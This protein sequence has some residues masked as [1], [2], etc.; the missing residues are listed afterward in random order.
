MSSLLTVDEFCDEFKVG[1]T[2]AYELMRAGK[3]E[4]VKIGRSTRI[5]RDSADT[6]AAALPRFIGGKP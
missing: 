4:A 5:T 3:I 2:R 1:R 6:W